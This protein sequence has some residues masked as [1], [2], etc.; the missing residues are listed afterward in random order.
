MSRFLAILASFAL[1]L[2]TGMASAAGAHASFTTAELCQI[3]QPCQPP[4]RFASGPFVVPPVIEKVTLRQVQSICGGGP[5]SASRDKQ[6]DLGPETVQA[7]LASAA[8]SFH[9]EIMGCAQLQATRC[10]VHVPAD[11]QSQLPDLYR[12][13]VAHELGHCRGW[14]HARY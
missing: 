7:A 3:L 11:L 9:S 2:P 1:L 14:V 12:L 4:A 10:V 13:I 5:S 6:G 8:S